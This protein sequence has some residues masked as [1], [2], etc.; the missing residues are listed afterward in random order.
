MGHEGEGLCIN[1]CSL[2]C[3]TARLCSCL[4]L[5]CCVGVMTVTA[6]VSALQHTIEVFHA[7]DPANRALVGWDLLWCDT[8]STLTTWTVNAAFAKSQVR[9]VN[10]N[11][12]HIIRVWADISIL[13]EWCT[14]PPI[15][16][17]QFFHTLLKPRRK[18][19]N[20]VRKGQSR[21]SSCHNYQGAGCTV[22]LLEM[23]AGL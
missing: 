7:T 3:A 4:F 19:H 14:N 20:T 2:D 1:V 18:N 15:S 23:L 11:V 16:F 22:G 9:H 5:C 21:A 17:T 10:K 8:I 13:P 12:R 6:C